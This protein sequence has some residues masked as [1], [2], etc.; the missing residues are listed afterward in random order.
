MPVECLVLE[1]HSAELAET[2]P[3]GW[4]ALNHAAL[5]GPT[6]EM[7]WDEV[8]AAVQKK[9]AKSAAAGQLCPGG[10]NLPTEWPKLTIAEMHMRPLE[11]EWEGGAAATEN[12]EE[13][14]CRTQQK[15]S[16]EPTGSQ[17]ESLLRHLSPHGVNEFV[18]ELQPPAA[19]M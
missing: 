14:V 12:L 15:P 6:G 17:Q 1:M 18:G 10:E 13:F 7:G 4:S 3:G 9:Q 5:T 16:A 19:V 11:L 2:E 8:F